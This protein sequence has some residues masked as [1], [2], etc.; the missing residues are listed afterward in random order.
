MPSSGRCHSIH[1]VSLA[2][3]ALVTGA[4]R[5]L[6]AVIAEHLAAD[7]LHV[8]VNYR[9]AAEGAEGAEALVARVRSQGGTAE[10]FAADVTAPADVR[11][12]VSAVSDRVGEIAVLVLNA[13]GPQPQLLLA[14][15][16]WEDHLA[17]LRFFVKSPVLLGR[18]VLPGMKRRGYGRIIHIG[19][20]VTARPTPDQSSYI[21]A[22]SAQLGLARAWALDLAAFGITVNT[23]A[24]GWIPV[25][26]HAGM[27]PA[28]F[29][30]YTAAVPA[31]HLGEPADV[32]Q[33]VSFL[34]SPA[35]G[36][37]T[38]EVL[39]VNGGRTMA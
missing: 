37:I 27:A 29:E 11:R 32:A 15:T 20:E 10:A 33:A 14:E 25:E 5:G 7:G 38:G 23:V 36:F 2:R 39:H 16:S 9:I 30:S 24:P 21:A 31:G 18:E 8:A 28:A 1:Q 19:S 22:K 17:H 13:T 6:G 3:T 34:A 26:R 4:S 35:A 12:L